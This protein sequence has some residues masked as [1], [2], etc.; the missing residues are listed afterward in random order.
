MLF[1]E[2]HQPGV[3]R[4][5]R[6]LHRCHHNIKTVVPDSTWKA[7]ELNG[8]HFRRPGAAEPVL[9][10]RCRRPSGFCSKSWAI[11]RW[12]TLDDY[13]AFLEMVLEQ[14]LGGDDT[15]PY[16]AYNKSMGVSNWP[17]A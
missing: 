14:K 4:T 1:A 8:E 2:L 11:P 7:V 12:K 16:V 5:G 9:E 10:L 6:Q 15:V 3:A 13:V 17:M